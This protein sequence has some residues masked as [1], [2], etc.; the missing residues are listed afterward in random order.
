[1]VTNQVQREWE[2]FFYIIRGLTYAF[3]W[4]LLGA[5]ALAIIFCIA[6]VLT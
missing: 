5:T 2:E 4:G 3:I 1:M 6:K